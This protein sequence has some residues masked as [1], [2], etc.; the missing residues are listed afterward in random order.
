VSDLING[1]SQASQEQAQGVDQVN[2]A[3]SQMDKVTQQNAAGAE[4]SASAAEEL[5]AQS[6]AVKGRVDELTALVHGQSARH[7]VGKTSFDKPS[8]GSKKTT[9][10]HP[11]VKKPSA[12][13]NKPV[14]V[15]GRN[16]PV[17]VAAALTEAPASESFQLSD[18]E[19]LKDF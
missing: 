17:P 5:A 16:K 7:S 14:P 19:D 8:A 12:I 9:A 6:M 2:T 18:T 11:S 10:G 3:V 15:A 1:I 4:E 13:K